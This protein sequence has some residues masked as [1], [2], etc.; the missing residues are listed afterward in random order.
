ML[1]TNY[2]QRTCRLNE[3]GV[4]V[5]VEPTVREAET[6]DMEAWTNEMGAALSCILKR[7]LGVH[8]EQAATYGVLHVVSLVPSEA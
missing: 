7:L 2:Q 3:R 1:S 5:L 6:P 8:W 4:Q